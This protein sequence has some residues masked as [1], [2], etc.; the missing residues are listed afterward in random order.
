MDIFVKLLVAGGVMG[1]LDFVWLGFIAKKLYYEEMGA[2]L[3]E[4]FNMVPALIFYVV[5]VVGVVILVVNPALAK[6]SLTHA[7]L[8]GALFGL[9]AYAT[10]DLTSLA[11]LKGFSTKIVVIDLVWGAILTAVVASVTYTVVRQWAS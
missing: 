11:V 10:Y 8:Y 1:I 7:A 6:D 2:I 3:L 5:Y 4:K 9:V